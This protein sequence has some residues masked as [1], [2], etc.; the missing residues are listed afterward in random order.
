MFYQKLQGTFALEFL[1]EN[2]EVV[3]CDFSWLAWDLVLEDGLG[4]LSYLAL[5]T[6]T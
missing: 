5:S 2:V 3:Y 4:L 6:N 1:V